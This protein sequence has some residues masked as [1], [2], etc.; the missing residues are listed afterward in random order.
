MN[1]PSTK[2]RSGL[3]AKVAAAKRSSGGN[4]NGSGSDGRVL[5]GADYVELMMGGRRKAKEEAMKLPRD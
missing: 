4:G 2:R 3:K 1:N 5:G